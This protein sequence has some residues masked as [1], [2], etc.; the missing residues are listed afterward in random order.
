MPKESG[1]QRLLAL[2][3]AV[4]Q[5]TDAL[6]GTE[7]VEREAAVVRL[8]DAICNLEAVEQRVKREKE[9]QPGFQ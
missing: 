2:R 5:A 4:E 1:W 6:R 3:S 9:P 8:R 7:G